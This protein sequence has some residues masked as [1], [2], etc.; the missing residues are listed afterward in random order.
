MTMLN[1]VAPVRGLRNKT[2]KKLSN[3]FENIWI[4]IH[5]K[6]K[7]EEELAESIPKLI[8]EVREIKAQLQETKKAS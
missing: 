4:T 8:D 2:F 3:C 1:T 7:V 6:K 5:G